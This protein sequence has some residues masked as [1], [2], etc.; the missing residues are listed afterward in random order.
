VTALA[1]DGSICNFP[2]WDAYI[3]TALDRIVLL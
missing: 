3:V 1:K 2:R